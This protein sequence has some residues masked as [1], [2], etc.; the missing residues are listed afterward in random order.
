MHHP[1]AHQSG[2]LADFRNGVTGCLGI[3]A[4][5]DPLFVDN[6]F[7]LQDREHRIFPDFLNGA[8]ETFAP[9]FDEIELQGRTSR[10]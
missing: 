9:V 2:L 4:R 8:A 7:T 10:V 1:V 3:I 6:V 5:G